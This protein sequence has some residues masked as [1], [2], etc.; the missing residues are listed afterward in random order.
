M[1]KT[2][3][4]SGAQSCRKIFVEPLRFGR[5][6]IIA[7]LLLLLI[8]PSAPAQ[9]PSRRPD[10]QNLFPSR[11]RIPTNTSGATPVQ[12][13]VDLIVSK[14]KV[15]VGETVSFEVPRGPKGENIGYRFYFGDGEDSGW[16]KEPQTTHQY[17][18]P[19]SPKTYTAHADVRLRALRDREVTVGTV[20]K[21]VE[22]VPPPIP[23]PTPEPTLTPTPTPAPTPTPTPTLTPKPTPVR[24]T[25]SPE[26][27]HIRVTPSPR[28]TRFRPTAT[29][30]PTPTPVIT[31][32][33]E[34]SVPWFYILLIGGLIA[35]GALAYSLKGKPV[36]LQSPT[37]HLHW[38][39]GAPETKRQENIAINYELHLDPNF[40]Q[41]KHE[42]DTRGADLITAIRRNN[43]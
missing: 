36:I 3:N 7:H 25:P 42:L 1:Q 15:E 4:D 30:S 9:T 19:S 23:T 34:G 39:R 22:V 6:I 37:F 13:Q 31:R 35:A 17:S 41:G 5:V 38:D 18:S 21:E 26:P 24:V 2:P 10:I 28:P 8:L 33:P 40:V 27:T 20:T 11:I 12:Q 14:Q 43:D 32:P 29:P 16:I